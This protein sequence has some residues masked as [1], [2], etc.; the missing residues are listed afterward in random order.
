MMRISAGALV[1]LFVFTAVGDAAIRPTWP[2]EYAVERAD[3]IVIGRRSDVK[4]DY[5]EIIV[6]RTL[7]GSVP[8]AGSRVLVRG[9]D[10]YET[11]GRRYGDYDNV[12]N[13]LNLAKKRVDLKDR[14]ILLCLSRKAIYDKNA[15]EN[16]YEEQTTGHGTALKVFD[17]HNAYGYY[18]WENPGPYRLTLERVSKDE[19]LGRVRRALEI[20][21]KWESIKALPDATKR[22]RATVEFLLDRTLPMHFFMEGCTA[23]ADA[24]L[25]PVIQ[26]ELE[27]LKKSPPPKPAKRASSRDD[28]FPDREGWTR[29]SY[30]LMY[31]K[32][33][34]KQLLSILEKIKTDMPDYSSSAV[35]CAAQACGPAA[36]PFL[37]RAFRAGEDVDSVAYGLVRIATPQ[38]QKAFERG[39]R[40][41]LEQHGGTSWTATRTFAERWPAAWKDFANRADKDFPNEPKVQKYLDHAWTSL[42]TVKVLKATELPARY[43]AKIQAIITRLG[44]AQFGEREAAMAELRLLLR[45]GSERDIARGLLEHAA[46]SSDVLEV[47]RRA[48][49]LLK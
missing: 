11:E 22:R 46:Q 47:R 36:I 28:Y 48:E 8:K 40:S 2:I 27:R 1:V 5:L 14:P 37:E 7:F 41:H 34:G 31:V 12:P 49:I 24:E 30:A 45:E 13:G 39:L 20:R 15:P 3:L 29:L 19:T 44:S 23:L 4:G 18:Q 43:T 21:P 32:D 25:I 26:D 9:L 6:E 38:A 10:G 17:H 16:A 42:V 35:R 33:D